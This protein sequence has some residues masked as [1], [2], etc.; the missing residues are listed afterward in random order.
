MRAAIYARYSSDLQSAQSIEDQVR[1][2]RERADRDGHQIIDVYADYA[3][4]G[5]HAASRPSLQ[6]LLADAR[7]R[8]FEIV[9]T[10]ALD[11]LSRDQEDTA[12][13]F[14]RLRHADVPILS[15]SEGEISE[16][17]VGMAGTMNA[18]YLKHLAD[19]IRRGQRG[20]IAAGFSPGGLS[21]GYDVVRELDA[22]GNLVRGKRR[23][24]PEQA[25]I[26]RRIFDE[27]A[28]GAA[29]RTIATSLNRDGVP[30]PTGGP[31]WTSTIS[32]NRQRRH[33][34]LY[35]EAYAGFLI[36]NRVR[37]VRDPETGKRLSRPNPP[38]DW[39]VV[40]A[41][42]LRIV[43][44]DTWDRCQEIK[45]R[46]AHKPLRDRRRPRRLLSGLAFCG[47][48]GGSYTV[49]GSDRMGCVAHRES[50]TCDNNRTISIRKLEDRV[51]A[52]MREHLLRPEAI[53][54]FVREYHAE[55][56]RRKAE[57]GRL[58]DS[59]VKELRDVT[60]RIGRIVEAIETGGDAVN[61]MARLRD[62][63]ARQ[64]ALKADI[65][66]ADDDRVLEIHPNLPERYRKIIGD[67]QTALNAP[68]TRTESMAIL[69]SMI[70]RIVLHAGERRGELRIELHGALVS[71]LALANGHRT[72][73]PALMLKLVAEEGLEPPTRGL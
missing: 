8:R 45:T 42:D 53:A 14:K 10:E 47:R 31:W 39:V 32:G 20:R 67:L 36:Y 18:L 5:S 44:Q 57:K 65:A 4:S 73:D 58:R 1:M 23:I 7:D 25:A 60:A 12:S 43:S 29:A 27:Y 51:L 61:L 15:L 70:D 48:C 55:A 22:D 63:E 64:V 37:M 49:I 52:G 16:L 9:L 46:Q 41:P 24:N 6:R 13:I 40:E 11:R 66:S 38:R 71:I 62:L 54:E 21:Y 50:G 68:D 35:N 56:R 17:H 19:K 28:G 33:G 3:L 26:V 30:G 72:P 59:A 34:F 2:C 69:R